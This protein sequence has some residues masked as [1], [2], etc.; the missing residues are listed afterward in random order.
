MNHI[1]II[2]V[3]FVL[4]LVITMGSRDPYSG[5]TTDTE[6]CRECHSDLVEHDVMHAP[7]EDACDNCHQSTGE[8][9]PADGAKGF[10]LT[11]RLP[12]LCFYCH[13]EYVPADHIHAPVARGEC[14]SCHD[15]HGSSE[16]M[17]LIAPEQVLCLR[18]HNREYRSDSLITENIGILV[19]GRST[20]H[21]AITDMGCRTCHQPHTSGYH[22]LLVDVYP[23]DRY[24]AANTGNFELC[25]LCHDTGIIDEEETDWA[26][27]FRNGTRNLHQLH[28][29][30]EKGRNCNL[31]HNIHGSEQKY[32][33]S[34]R[35]TFGSWEMRMNF[36]PEDDGGSCLPGCHDYQDYA[37]S[38]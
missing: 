26:T 27:N 4:S 22:S 28:I 5:R 11:D 12:E 7:A 31:C 23:R 14:L 2:L 3:Q 35:V 20:A 1:F 21:T 24:V 37:R 13:E 36:I 18:C 25:F 32:L 9:H 17:I 33:I 34:E 30:G 29:R 8:S 16:P 38:R 19:K 6:N 10:T 15:V